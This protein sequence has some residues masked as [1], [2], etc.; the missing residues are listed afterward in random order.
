VNQKEKHTCDPN[1]E[2]VVQNSMASDFSEA[3]PRTFVVVHGRLRSGQAL[4]NGR[5]AI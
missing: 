1:G 4:F 3:R 5:F 2:Q